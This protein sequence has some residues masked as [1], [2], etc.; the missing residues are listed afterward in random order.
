MGP[1]GS[2]KSTL[3]HILAGLDKPTS[4]TVMIAGTEITGLDDSQLTLL[5]R[6]HIGFVFQFFNLLPMLNA[7]ENVVLPLSIAGE[8]PD[9]AWLDALLD[10][11]GPRRPARA[12]ARPSSRAASSSAS[13]SRARSSRGRR[14]SSP[15]SRPATSTRRRAARSSSSMRTSTDAYGQTTVMV[16]HE[17]R[18]AAIADRILFLADGQIVQELGKHAEPAE[19]LE[20]MNSLELMIRVALRGMARRKLRTALTAI[21]IVLGVAL[22][23]GTYVL[24]DSIKGAFGGI[25]TSVYRGTDATVTGKSAFTLS[26]Q[27]NTTAPPFDAVAAA[28]D[29]RPAGRRG[30]GRRRRRDRAPHRRRQGRRLRRRAEPRLQRRPDA[31]RAQLA[32]ARRR[33]V[34]GAEPG[35]DRRG[36][37]AQEGSAGRADDRRAGERADAPHEDLRPRALRRRGEPRRRD[38]LG[39]R[40]ADRRSGSSSASGKLDQI[41]AKAK[42]G[43]SPAKLAAEIRA[44]P[45]AGHA[46]EDRRAAG[47]V[48]RE[49]HR[50]L[51]QLPPGLPA[52]VRRDRAVRRLAS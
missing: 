48:R 7:E 14:S 51:P 26:G 9:K 25:F 29:P 32:H 49:G 24:T 28:E 30:R 5:R 50:E 41:R 15:T 10:A 19:V 42:P 11:D 38:A 43:V 8:K 40:P 27:S 22:I 35:R 44:D 37:R 39:L 47:E 23:T 45:A 6:E 52:R 17:A 12:T 21:A 18:A 36:D 20:V 31:A 33:D 2:G 46:G 34:A 3:M 1:S 4:G 13:R 16:T